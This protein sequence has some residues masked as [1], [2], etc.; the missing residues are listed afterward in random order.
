MFSI[1]ICGSSMKIYFLII[2]QIF[3]NNEI[4]P[5]FKWF[6]IV[7]LLLFNLQRDFRDT[8]SLN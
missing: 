8:Y 5:L 3:C 6:I 4:R 1:T 7:V 2:I